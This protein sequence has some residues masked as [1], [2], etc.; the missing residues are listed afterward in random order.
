M[1]TKPLIMLYCCLHWLK[2]ILLHSF[3]L[4]PQLSYY[5]LIFKM[6]FITP[7]SILFNTN[8]RNYCCRHCFFKKRFAIYNMC[9][10]CKY[11]LRHCLKV[12]KY[13]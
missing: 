3:F 2:D 5:I 7:N 10:N 12:G 1:K 9:S 8:Y 4:S 13:T 6:Y 11:L